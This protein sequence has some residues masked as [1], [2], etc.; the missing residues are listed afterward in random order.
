[1]SNALVLGL[2]LRFSGLDTS[3]VSAAGILLAT[4]LIMVVNVLP[5][6][7]INAIIVPQLSS[8][9]GLTTETEQSEL[10][11]ALALYRATTWILPMMIGAV[12]FFVWRYRVRGDT[13]TTVN[14]DADDGAGAEPG[15][16]D[17]PPVARPREQ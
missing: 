7:G 16:A 9:L 17:D 6:P 11:A 12:M 15:G 2:A 4:S 13:V 3:A 10:T 14:E 8:I 1:L 5:I